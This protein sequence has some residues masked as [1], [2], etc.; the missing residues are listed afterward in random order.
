M[1]HL[2]GP[3]IKAGA[4]VLGIVT[5][6]AGCA[7]TEATRCG[8]DT[9]CS[10]RTMCDLPSGACVPTDVDT[11]NTE[12]PAT[13]QFVNKAIPFFRGRVCAPLEVQ[14]GSAFPVR[15]NPCLHP[16]IEP[17]RRQINQAWNC[18]GS[19]C[20]ALAVLWIEGNS[21]ASGCPEDAFGRFDRALCNWSVEQTLSIQPVLDNGDPVQGIMTLE[22][23]YLSNEDAA[24]LAEDPRNFTLL[25][26]KVDQYP[27]D[28][29]RFA[30]DVGISLLPGNPAPPADCAT[31]G[32][33]ECFRIGF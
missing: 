2:D 25:R 8:A 33:C 1:P 7:P 21:T 16:C 6:S 12:D 31:D 5:W 28:E 15:L 9:E 3:G 10:S 26:E 27:V 4:W 30:G 13:P 18:V 20:E 24:E 22:V 19:S 17:A 23:P 29:D 14:A 32:D 11:S